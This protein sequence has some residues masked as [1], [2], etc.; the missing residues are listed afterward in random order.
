MFVLDEIFLLLGQLAFLAEH[1]K[2]F[3]RTH[4][5]A[6]GIKMWGKDGNDE[7]PLLAESEGRLTLRV[8]QMG[9]GRYGPFP[10]SRCWYNGRAVTIPGIA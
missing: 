3:H 9:L 5:A 8:V 10:L 1:R 6:H 4:R 2:E 7:T